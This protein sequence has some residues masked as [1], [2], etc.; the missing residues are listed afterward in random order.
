MDTT[1]LM[2][3]NNLK[4][5]KELSTIPSILIISTHRLIGESL[6]ASLRLLKGS[7]N[8]ILHDYGF[9]ETNS[10]IEIEGSLIGIHIELL[11]KSSKVLLRSALKYGMTI[12][13][14]EKTYDD[15]IMEG[16]TISTGGGYTSPTGQGTGMWYTYIKESPIIDPI[17]PV[18]SQSPR[19]T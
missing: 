2:A 4:V 3:A 18:L 6:P 5:G 13:G 9:I 19:Y 14:M 7:V 11:N 8:G 12:I 16:A 1:C 10:N 17:H 15:C